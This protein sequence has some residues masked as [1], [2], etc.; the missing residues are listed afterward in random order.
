MRQNITPAEMEILQY[1]LDHAPL[2]V[3]TVADHFGQTKGLART[4]V[5]SVMENLRQKGHLKRE[6]GPTGYLYSPGLPKAEMQRNMIAEFIE[7]SL[8]GSLS[9]FVA[10]LAEREA[11]DEAERQE[12]NRLLK[13]LEGSEQ[14]SD[15]AP[16]PGSDKSA[17][18][19]EDR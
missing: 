19:R 11:L 16:D 2:T 17:E 9:P 18:E 5:L 1:V 3:R 6:A 15:N 12:V 8:G 10:Y 14:A 4:T 7:R 13:K